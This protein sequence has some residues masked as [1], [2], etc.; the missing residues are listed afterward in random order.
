MILIN[1]LIDK[2]VLPYTLMPIISLLLILVLSVN[3]QTYLKMVLKLKLLNTVLTIP[4]FTLLLVIFKNSPV[5]SAAIVFV[6]KILFLI[7]KNVYP[8]KPYLPY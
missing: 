3:L 6:K 1:F 7:I 4:G 5:K 2:M 8:K